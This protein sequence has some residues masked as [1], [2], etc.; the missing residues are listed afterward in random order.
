MERLEYFVAMLQI[1]I[2]MNNICLVG[3]LISKG[4]KQA[5]ACFNNNRN[6]NSQ[7]CCCSRIGCV[8]RIRE[9]HL[10]INVI[11]S[12]IDSFLYMS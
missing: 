10:N 11:A 2:K 4:C 12:N 8:L 7:N 1:K 5:S 9:E 3:E 6:P